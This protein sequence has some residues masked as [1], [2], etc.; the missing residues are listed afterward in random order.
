MIMIMLP[1]V[2][3]HLLPKVSATKGARGEEQIAPRD[4]MALISPSLDPVGLPK[5]SAQ[6]ETV[7]REFIIEPSYPLVMYERTAAGKR[8]P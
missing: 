3:P 2:I 5:K 4:K 6:Y 7:W 8:R 1:T